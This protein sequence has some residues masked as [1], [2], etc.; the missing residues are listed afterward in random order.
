MTTTDTLA[1][2][3]KVV[4]IYA[5]IARGALDL[6]RGDLG[7]HGTEEGR[8]MELAMTKYPGGAPVPRSEALAS[9]QRFRAALAKAG[10]HAPVDARGVPM[11]WQE[12]ALGRGRWIA[13][14]PEAARQLHEARAALATRTRSGGR[15]T[16]RA[17][18]AQLD[19]AMAEDRAIQ[20][21]ESRLVATYDADRRREAAAAARR[22][23][24]AVRLYASLSEGQVLAYERFCAGG[25]LS[26]A[27]PSLAE[28]WAKQLHALAPTATYEMQKARAARLAAA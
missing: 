4:V 22:H 19:A 28:C 23:A 6:A 9:A 10:G 26:S 13:R 12:D 7:Q 2:L 21:M 3:G 14:T 24:E 18:Q 11:L 17:A 1:A 16:V 5:G 20:G 25:G 15:L 8:T 27:H